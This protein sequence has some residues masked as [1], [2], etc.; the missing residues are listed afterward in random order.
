MPVDAGLVDRAQFHIPVHRARVLVVDDENGPRQAL[1]MLL[2]EE[3]DVLVA[4]DVPDAIAQLRRESVDLV[5]TDL[6]MPK[7]SGID[8]LRWVKEFRP[9]TQVIILTGFAALDTAIKAVEHGAFAY[10]EKPFD[11]DEM[12]RQVQAAYLKRQE[13]EDRRKF[14]RAVLEGNRFETLGR[15][16]AGVM[17]DLGG[18]LA[19]IETHVEML[20]ERPD[21]TDLRE[22]LAT[23]QTQIRHC[24]DLA[25]TAMNFVR[26]HSF[27]IEAFCLND[28][29]HK[30]LS[31]AGPILRKQTVEAATDLCE[32]LPACQGDIVLA[33]Q[34]VLNLITNACHAMEGQDAPRRIAIR[35]WFEPEVGAVCLSVGDSGPG[36]PLEHR[37]NVFTTFFTSKG[38]DGT[39]LG[40]AIVRSVMERHG[41]LVALGE[42]PLGGAL[43]VLK[44][45]LH[46]RPAD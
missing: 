20:L 7:H 1:R 8:L 37:P 44:F 19:V 13:E 11:N 22:R 23:L 33:R 2:K 43:F 4:A 34:A 12:I 30:C 28:V 29:V 46:E 38:E 24:H 25:G 41:G 16:L 31:V 9:E 17:H 6:R 21:R 36:V 10:I 3:H 5:I 15:F 45:P 26:H 39:G 35:S 32:E 27:E 14:E 18:P 42:S 40:L